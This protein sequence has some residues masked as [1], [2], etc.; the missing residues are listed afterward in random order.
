MYKII[1]NIYLLCTSPDL[2]IFILVHR[3]QNTDRS[4]TELDTRQ[5]LDEMVP[6]PNTSSSK[7]TRGGQ[8]SG[9]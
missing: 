4:L 1:N 8:E 5:R 3:D 7:Q 9:R 2:F 6:G